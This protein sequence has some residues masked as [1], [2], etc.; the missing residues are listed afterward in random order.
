MTAATSASL[1]DAVLATV[2]YA[3][4]FDMPIELEHLHRYL[5]QG[6]ATLVE[7]SLAV[8]DL[9]SQGRLGRRN[10]VIYLSGR[11]DVLAIYDERTERAST[12]W[13]DAEKWGKR[14]GRLPFVR[15]VAVTGGLAVDSVA[16]HD[17]IDYFIVIRPGRL[18]L[19]RLMIIVLG[20]IADRDDVDVC[21]NFIVSD[22]AMSMTQETIYVARELAQM[23]VIVGDD[24]CQEVRRT[25]AWMFGFLPNAT[26]EGDR[27]RCSSVRPTVMQR[28][29]EWLLLLPIFAPV[30]KWEMDRKIVKL[31]KVAS[32]RPE[33]GTPDES[34]FSVD[35][36]K[37][38]MVGNAAGIDIAWKQRLSNA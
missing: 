29:A 18:W 22:R 8:D 23:V 10:D 11:A 7:T 30:E 21:P 17:D 3:D 5:V 4:V 38:H 9:V 20:R 33:V 35:V 16:D 2:S 32:R 19:T 25:N 31:G 24:L 27:S 13:H 37:G 6:E 26:I 15:M 14:I 1:P 12:M 36:C 28:V 34:S